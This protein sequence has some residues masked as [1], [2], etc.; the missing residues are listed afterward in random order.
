MKN[1]HSKNYHNVRETF[2]VGNKVKF[3]SDI[4]ELLPAKII[5]I[6]TL[7]DLDL[8]FGDNE[9]GTELTS[10]CWRV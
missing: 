5:R 1:I 7:G 8:E 3:V 6:T 2:H 9:T 10:S 4:G